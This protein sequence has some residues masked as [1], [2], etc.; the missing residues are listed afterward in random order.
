M[1]AAWTALMQRLPRAGSTCGTRPLCRRMKLAPERPAQLVASEAQQQE[2][3]AGFLQVHRDAGAHVVHLAD[4]A[5]QESRRDR[6]A[7][8][9]VG[10]LVVQAVLARDEWCAVG[11]RDV[12]AGLGGEHQRAQRLGPLGV[13]PAEIIEQGDALGVG[14]DG[15]AVANGLVDHTA[16]HGIRVEPAVAR[17]DAAA[18]GQ[19]ATRAAHRHDHGR[20]AGAVVAGR[21][22]AAARPCALDLVIVLADDPLLAAHVPMPEQG[23]QVG[24]EIG[25]AGSSS[26]RTGG[27]SRPPRARRPAGPRA[28]S[29]STRSATVSPS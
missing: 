16:G 19:S 20:V 25:F 21:R 29:P 28:E 2:D 3:V 12:V 5:D 10:V 7:L 1:I 9:L 24:R 15:D 13:A 23:E 18:D 4:G 22:P 6:Q 26:G 14:P 8:S 17:V 11:E 27:R